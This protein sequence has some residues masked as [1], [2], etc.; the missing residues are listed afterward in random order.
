M[1]LSWSPV[2]RRANAQNRAQAL[3]FVA[4]TNRMLKQIVTYKY[5]FLTFERHKIGPQVG[6][7]ALNTESARFAKLAAEG[8]RVLSV[9]PPLDDAR[10]TVLLELEIR[11]QAEEA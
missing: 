7:L 5:E 11:S 9:L 1:R 6:S 2:K 10:I 4:D 8:W 3:A